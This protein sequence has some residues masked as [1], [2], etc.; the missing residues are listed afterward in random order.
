M[1]GTG[2]DQVGLVLGIPVLQ[3]GG[4]LEEV[5]VD[6]AGGHE[7]VGVDPAGD[8]SDLEFHVAEQSVLLDLLEQSAV[9]FGVG[10]DG[11]RFSGVGGASVL[12]GTAG[13]HAQCRECSQGDGG[14]STQHGVPSILRGG[15]PDSS[16]E[17]ADILAFNRMK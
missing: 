1:H 7:L 3:V 8:L 17:P 2:V 16:A 4:V 5:D 6:V 13:G 15:L 9:R 12:E 14:A 10:D 11:Q